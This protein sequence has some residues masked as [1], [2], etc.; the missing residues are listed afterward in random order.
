MPRKTTKNTKEV[1]QRKTKQKAVEIVVETL[2]I[3][4][5]VETPEAEV[6]V[7]ESTAKKAFRAYMEDYKIKN[8][9]KYAL[10]EKT[11]LAQLEQIK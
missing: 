4:T 2:Q 5:P 9:A 10:K 1:K 3:E 8:P 7:E 11:F 6:A